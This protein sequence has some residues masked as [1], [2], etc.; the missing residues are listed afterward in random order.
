M[1]IAA[2]PVST[3]L[4]LVMDNGTG[5]SGQALSVNRSF[6]DIKTTA[7]NADLY[8]VAQTLIGLQ[9]KSTLSVQRRDINEI[10]NV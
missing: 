5:T 9:S 10:Q 3:D 4:V 1:A 8:D 2:N 6:K 7:A